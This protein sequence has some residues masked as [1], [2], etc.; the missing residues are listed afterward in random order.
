M[1]DIGS[2]LRSTEA[3]APRP[4]LGRRRPLSNTTVGKSC[5]RDA[6]GSVAC[7]AADAALLRRARNIDVRIERR[8]GGHRQRLQH[9]ADRTLAATLDVAAIEH[10]YGSHGFGRIQP[11]ARAVDDHFLQRIA[12][13]GRS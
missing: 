3:S 7:R 10:G 13:R 2:V 1:K 9:V 6:D 5:N 4:L 11:P 12:R 8:A